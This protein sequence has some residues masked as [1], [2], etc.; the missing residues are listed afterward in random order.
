MVIANAKKSTVAQRAKGWA[1]PLAIWSIGPIAGYAVGCL[2]DF[3]Q[4][5][6]GGLFE[7][8]ALIEP[9]FGLA[10]F[11]ELILVLGPLVSNQGFTAAN[12]GL[13]R[14][15]LRANGGLMFLSEGLAL[16]AV[17]AD[18]ASTFLVIAVTIPMVIQLYLLIDCAYNRVGIHRIRPG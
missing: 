8:C 2:A 16:Y 9:L 5:A 12:Q 3:G 14:A 1:F 7:V 13:A 11:V 4:E 6:Q 10:V 18:R 17:A 15:V